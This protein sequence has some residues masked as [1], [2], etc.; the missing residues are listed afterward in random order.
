MFLGIDGEHNG[1]DSNVG[2]DSD[3]LSNVRTSK[4]NITPPTKEKRKP[5]FKKV[6]FYFKFILFNNCCFQLP[7]LTV[8]S[9]IQVEFTTKKHTSTS[10]YTQGLRQSKNFT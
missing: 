2:E 4:P 10:V 3:S 1:V 8:F 5:F 7:L 6:R 9:A